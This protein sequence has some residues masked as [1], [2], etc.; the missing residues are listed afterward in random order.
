MIKAEL[1]HSGQYKR[2]GDTFR[3]WE[4]ETDEPFEAVKDYCF[5]E[6]YV[7]K[8]EVPSSAEWHENIKVGGAKSGDMGYYFRGYYILTKTNWNETELPARYKF[9]VCEPFT[10]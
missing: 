5:K 9:E 7:R 1:V 4:I 10:D 6:L 3:V 8:Y 2:Y